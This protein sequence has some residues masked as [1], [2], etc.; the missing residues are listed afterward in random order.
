MLAAMAG[1][2]TTEFDIMETHELGGV[3]ELSQTVG[4]SSL[5]NPIQT[6]DQYRTDPTRSDDL[7][8]SHPSN[9]CRFRGAKFDLGAI[10]VHEVLG[11]AYSYAL[12]GSDKDEMG[13]TFT[14]N[15]Y[16]EQ[17]NQPTRCAY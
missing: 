14:E 6:M 11:H 1:N 3:P 16:H 15:V 13:A 17:E 10:I 8:P 4:T 9:S 5:I 7:D 2:P 12:G